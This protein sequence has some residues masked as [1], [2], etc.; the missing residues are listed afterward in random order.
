MTIDQDDV[1]TVRLPHTGMWV[2]DRSLSL[3]AY[4]E[5]STPDGVAFNAN[6]RVGK[7][8]VGT[9]EQTGRG[10]MTMFRWND[11]RT[12]GENHLDEYAA[13]C[14]TA[15]GATVTSED[16][17][18]QLVEEH[19][20]TRKTA[21]AERKGR[22]TLRLIGHPEGCGFDDTEPPYA[23][24]MSGCRPPT[25]DRHWTVLAGQVA[26][27]MPPGESSWWQGWTG[28]EWRDITPRPAIFNAEL[29]S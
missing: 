23:Y 5:M 12:F 13:R 4:K 2:P 6:L 9:V 7:K 15:E 10:G 26:S 17:L 18:N 20:W 22:M 3:T 24:N 14:R 25:E 1:T 11:W 29:Y 8:V 19:D 21:A 28:T 27:A 16:L